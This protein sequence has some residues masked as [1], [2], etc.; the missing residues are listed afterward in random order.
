TG[1]RHALTGALAAVAL[2][3][4]A[5]WLAAGETPREAPVRLAQAQPSPAAA[6]PFDE[7]QKD[8]IRAII[9]DY[10]LENPEVM[11]EV[12]TA[13]EARMEKLQAEKLKSA[14]QSNAAE[15]FRRADAPIA[16]N[17]NGDIPV[18]EF[19]DYNCGYCKR[20]FGDIAKLV[21]QD[22]KIKLVLKELP[23]LSKGS[24]EGSRVALA[25]RLQG[26][27]WAVHR[28]LIAL[29]GEINEQTALKAA[30]KVGGIDMA[31]LKA[32]MTSDAVSGEIARVREL[33]QKMGIQGTPHF[34]VGDR[35]IPGA[36]GNLLEQIK[37]N[38][39]ELRKSGCPV[40]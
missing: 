27:Y 28:A 15:I 5:S 37:T 29:R 26:K 19:F 22:S 31:K 18:V 4:G 14:L 30:E 10:L 20:A 39:A 25:A 33:A 21:E 6:S 7:R 23:I 38:V 9:K 24:E 16:G 40:C 36:P 8:A 13:L 3:G 34:L 17:P 12:Q 32:D 2:A 11:L 1:L 35:A